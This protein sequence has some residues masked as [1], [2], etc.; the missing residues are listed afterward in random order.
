L[1]A[2]PASATAAQQNF[3]QVEW[4][5]EFGGNVARS[6]KFASAMIVALALAGCA[7]S[8]QELAQT[9]DQKCRTNK[10]GTA[11]YDKC[12]ATLDAARQQENLARAMRQ[13]QEMTMRDAQ[14]ISRMGR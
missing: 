9:D 2:H 10:P 4:K 14:Y 5:P 7:S 6:I 3:R 11:E 1:S 13:Q 12:R 8:S